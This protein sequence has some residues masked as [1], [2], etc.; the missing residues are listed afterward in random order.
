ML[1]LLRLCGDQGD[2]IRA[3]L[4]REKAMKLALPPSPG[5]AS[6]LLACVTCRERASHPQSAGGTAARHIAAAS[7]P[8]RMPGRQDGKDLTA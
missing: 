8:L 6:Q 7:T 4:R 2:L 1:L 5:P 3:K